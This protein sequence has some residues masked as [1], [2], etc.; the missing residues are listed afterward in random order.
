MLWHRLQADVASLTSQK[1]TEREQHEI[2]SAKL[3]EALATSEA[4]VGDLRAQLAEAGGDHADTA[5]LLTAEQGKVH[6]YVLLTKAV[7]YSAGR[8]LTM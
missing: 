3:R 1:S 8:R 5:R 2:T 7:P 6:R 4:H